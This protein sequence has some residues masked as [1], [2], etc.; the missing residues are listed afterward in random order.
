MKPRIGKQ[1][2][3]FTASVI[4]GK[5]SQ[6]TKISLSDFIGQKVVLYFYPKNN[7]PG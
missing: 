7:T 2:P 6:E 1:A 3:D 5:Y 4:G